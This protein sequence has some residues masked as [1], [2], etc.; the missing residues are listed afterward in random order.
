MQPL[1]FPAPRYQPP[2]QMI[3]IL[4]KFRL[5]KS[6]GEGWNLIKE[7]WW[8]GA[9]WEQWRVK[10]PLR[11]RSSSRSW[12][13][14]GRKFTLS[15]LGNCPRQCWC[16]AG[17]PPSTCSGQHHVG[18]LKSL[19]RQIHSDWAAVPGSSQ[20]K[21]I[22]YFQ[23]TAGSASGAFL[24]SQRSPKPSGWINRHESEILRLI[25]TRMALTLRLFPSSGFHKTSLFLYY[26]TPLLVLIDRHTD[27]QTYRHTD[28]QTYRHTDIQT[29]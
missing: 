12:S 7:Q 26:R 21:W 16:W 29:L 2:D 17:F 22:I 14:A 20:W 19:F 24:P 8:R 5:E 23:K 18:R 6:S 9:G 25:S 28:I 4:G 27:I 10:K 13:L 11:W 3:R 15:L 1:E